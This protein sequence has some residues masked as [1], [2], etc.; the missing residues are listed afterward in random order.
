MSKEPGERLSEDSPEETAEE[1][2]KKATNRLSMLSEVIAGVEGSEESKVDLNKPS[3][4]FSFQKL[5][6]E[7]NLLDEDA[8]NL[9]QEEALETTVANLKE[10]IDYVSPQLKNFAEGLIMRA[11]IYLADQKSKHKK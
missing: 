2:A 1:K 6:A 3:H 11:G 7:G 4:V 8:D 10:Y 9:S 5:D